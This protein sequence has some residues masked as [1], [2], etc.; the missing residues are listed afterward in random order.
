[1][2]I[3][4]ATHGNELVYRRRVTSEELFYLVRVDA[5]AKVSE[6]ESGKVHLPDRCQ[7]HSHFSLE[8]SH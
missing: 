3:L 5:V 2:S 1:M 7:F 8:V 4:E 6:K